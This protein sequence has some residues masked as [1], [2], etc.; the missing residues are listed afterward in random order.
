MEYYSTIPVFFRKRKECPALKKKK[1]AIPYP[2]KR[3]FYLLQWHLPVILVWSVAL[4][5][6][7]L[8]DYRIDPKGAGY[9]YPALLEYITSSLV[10]SLIL[11]IVLDLWDRERCEN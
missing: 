4:L 8:S 11:A 3:A 5:V 2:S 9:Y 10:L 6:T 7:F 1:W